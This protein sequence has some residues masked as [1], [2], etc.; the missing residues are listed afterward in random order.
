M[1]KS[2]PRPVLNISSIIQCASHLRI[3]GSDTVVH[4]HSIAWC[5]TSNTKKKHST[6]KTDDDDDWR[7]LRVRH[8]ALEGRGEDPSV[9]GESATEKCIS[10]KSQNC[11]SRGYGGED[12]D[13]CLS[14][15]SSEG[16]I[17]SSSRSYIVEPGSRLRFRW[18]VIQV[19]ALIYLSLLVPIRVSMDYTA[20]GPGFWIE[21]LIDVYFWADICLNFMTAVH[22]HT[23]TFE[24]KTLTSHR[25]IAK[26]YLRTW[27]VLDLVAALPIDYANRYV[28]GTFWCSFY[29]H[30]CERDSSD[31]Q[32]QAL[33]LFK[34]FRTFRLLKLCRL[35]RI[36]RLIE[37]YQDD[38]I[39]W[40][41]VI[42][43][44]KLILILGF[45]SHWIG[46]CYAMVYE[47]PSETTVRERYIASLYFAMQTITTVGYGDMVTPER[48]GETMLA[49]CFSV[50]AMGVGGIIFGW[51]I[52]NVLSALNPE[53]HQRKH[54]ERLHAVMSY[55]R[56]NRIPSDIARR[57]MAHVRNQNARQGEDRA[58][59]A[60]LPNQLRVEVFE[61]LYF[62]L[63]ETMHVFRG[64]GGGFH[65][66]ALH[67]AAPDQLPR[68]RA[69]LFQV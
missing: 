31:T 3:Y 38:L 58:V 33:R 50:V 53:R 9:E 2:W 49:R 68:R 23:N 41:P 13:A 43:S 36:S 12:S 19:V 35:Y 15:P 29:P 17:S 26:H 69:G 24:V 8:G 59:L 63:L 66:A 30:G 52:T 45:A 64:A 47:F 37:K 21:F 11:R 14:E 54:Q 57:V 67:Q 65:P 10:L 44:S 61:Q 32:N 56:A 34:L 40:M 55:L 39:Y 4:L 28:N 5:Y 62:N 25:D 7:P 60:D 16:Y 1:N 51:L 22:V 18:D 20:T 27:F 48:G 46:C 42:T 6:T